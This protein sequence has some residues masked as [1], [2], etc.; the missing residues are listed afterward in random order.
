MKKVINLF[1]NLFLCFFIFPIGVFAIEICP[2][3][4]EYAEWLKIPESERDDF[5]EPHYCEST[6]KN[7]FT[8]SKMDGEYL[9]N[10]EDI[11]DDTVQDDILNASISASRYSA[12]DDKLVT[13]VKDQ[14][15]TNSCWAFTTNSLIETTA[16][17]EGLG[18]YD[19]SERQLEYGITRNAF[20]DKVKADGLNRVLDEGGNSFY[21]SSLYFRHEGPIYEST[22]PY[23]SPHQKIESSA[24][25][26]S[27]AVLDIDTFSYEYFSTY[28]AC[29]TNQIEAIKK[30]IVEYGSAGASMYFANGYLNGKYYYYSGS[31]AANHAVVIVGWD[32]NIAV[33]NFNNSP[34]TK[35]AWIVKNSWGTSFGDKGYIYISYSDTKI[36]GNSYNYSGI[37]LN[38]YNYA[39]AAS[40]F[41]SAYN[42]TLGSTTNY[43]S[44][45]F[46]KKGSGTEYLDKVSFEVVSG[47]KYEVYL[48][49]KNNVTDMSSWTKLGNGTATYDGIVS[50][51]FS[52]ITISGDYTVIVKRS[53]SGY[54]IPL[55]CKSGSSTSKYYNAS[56][57][58]GKNFY[59]HDGGSWFDMALINDSGLQGCE[60]VIY[61]YT[62]LQKSGSATFS[63]NSI[64][65]NK[66]KVYAGIGDYYTANIVTSGIQSYES[67]KID[68]FNEKGTN[69][70]SMF[71]IKN[72]IQNGNVKI[73]PEG[74]VAA[75]N[76]TLRLLYGSTSTSKSFVVSRLFD[77]SVYYMKNGMLVINAKTKTEMSKSTFISTLKLNVSSY[78]ILNGNGTDVTSST[79]VVGTNYRL[80]ADGRTIYI[81]LIGD[82]SGDGKILSNDSLQISRFLVDLRSLN[83]VYA[84]AADVSG[85]GKIL[86][87]DSLLISRFLV[88][89]KG[90]L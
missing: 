76:Y 43:M 34:T 7:Q 53:G 21:S 79:S 55:M 24:Y 31:N 37:S 67:F 17:V 51:K 33:S 35:G 15:S 12:V 86:S 82:I 66:S 40:D 58:S 48:S 57:T 39:Y 59:S 18:S 11:T 54:Y 56:I 26:N 81:A 8:A 2:M 65:G 1:I 23:V 47:N 19:L 87:N 14:K 9:K 41:M 27:K 83:G 50:V 60:P 5:I 6:F 29:T 46:T 25:P 72:N 16:L 32:D 75:G 13:S 38:D 4:Q 88:G 84:L 69:V 62:K 22:F 78:K 73:T 77:S 30:R 63:I 28:S 68:I 42:V 85:D 44:A 74:D 45:R 89:L 20:T 36:C 71:T 3:S 52:P 70:T 64:T 90:S 80:V 61:S 49:L 10:N